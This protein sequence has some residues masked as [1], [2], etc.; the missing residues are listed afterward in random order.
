ME[1][2][3]KSNIVREKGKKFKKGKKSKRGNNRI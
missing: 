1:K 2:G 3:K